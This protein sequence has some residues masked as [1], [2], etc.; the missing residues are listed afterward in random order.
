MS[1][2]P[3]WCAQYIGLPFVEGGRDRSGLDCYGLLRLV[4]NE[5][6]A[7]SVPEYEGIAWRAGDD[8]NLL[9]SLMDERVRLEEV[10][11]ELAGPIS[12]LLNQALAI[13][14]NARPQTVRAFDVA[15]D[16][17]LETLAIV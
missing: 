15:L 6:Y 12:D 4:I 16:A 17:V 8:K 13:D 11:P 14:Q 10:R 9:A 5:R 3:D 2:L 7:G 1:D